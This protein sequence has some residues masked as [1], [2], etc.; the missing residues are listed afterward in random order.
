M[1]DL[2]GSESFRTNALR[3]SLDAPIELNW[4]DL[5]I[6]LARQIDVYP[7]PFD[8][9]I[10]IQLLNNSADLGLIEIRDVSGRLVRLLEPSTDIKQV[11]WDGRGATGAPLPSGIYLMRIEIGNELIT[12]RVVK[13]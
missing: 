1:I 7:N 11:T 8:E 5:Q 9:T 2:Y 4:S 10:T 3:G 6:E 13:N 12:K